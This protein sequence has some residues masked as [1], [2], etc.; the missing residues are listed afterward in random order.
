MRRPEFVIVSRGQKGIPEDQRSSLALA[1]VGLD[2]LAGPL[3]WG[4]SVNSLACPLL[5]W[6]WVRRGWGILKVSLNCKLC[7]FCCL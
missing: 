1:G 5:G 6:G 2:G 4:A 3:R 7:L